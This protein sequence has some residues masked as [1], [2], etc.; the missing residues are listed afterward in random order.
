M[1]GG[2]QYITITGSISYGI[3]TDDSDFDTVGFCIPPKEMIFPHLA[4]EIP[5]FGRQLQRFDVW[6]HHHC[7]DAD[8][9]GGRGRTYDFNV[10]S[11]V[12]FFQLAM[13]NNPNMID[14]LFT[15]RECVLHCTKILA[16]GAGS[17]STRSRS[18]RWMLPRTLSRPSAVL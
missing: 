1:L 15:P 4:G 7:F 18:S 3:N 2:S 17:V 11:I 5:G 12:K 10:Y 14:V 6:E 8:A 9:L 13:D 16:G